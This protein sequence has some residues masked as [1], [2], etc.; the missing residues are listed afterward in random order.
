MFP[1]R[2]ANYRAQPHALPAELQG[3][4]MLKND[5]IAFGGVNYK[6]CG[7]RV[8]ECFWPLLSGFELIYFPPVVHDSWTQPS[9]DAFYV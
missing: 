5:G 7:A 3:N 9:G 2:A 6:D 4:N 8:N 1:L